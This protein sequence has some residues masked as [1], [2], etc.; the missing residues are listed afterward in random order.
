MASEKEAAA[1]NIVT[2]IKED[3]LFKTAQTIACY[4]PI[5]HE[6]N[7][8]PL[9]DFIWQSHKKCYLPIVLFKGAVAIYENTPLI[10]EP[11]QNLLFIHYEPHSKLKKNKFGILEPANINISLPPSQLDLVFLP[12]IAFDINGNRLGT[13][14]GYYDRTFAFLKNSTAN[15][16]PLLV[17][18]A[19]EAQK[20]PQLPSDPW[21]VPLDAVLTEKKLYRF[22]KL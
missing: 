14:G 8:I 18:L 3:L 6:L 21:D 10:N 1:K 15:K 11:P 2:L 5:K 22:D 20:A 19:Y 13:G 4:L 12:L 16:N 17:G 7:T 9:I